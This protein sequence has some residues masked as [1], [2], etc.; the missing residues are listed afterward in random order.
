MQRSK[1]E[2]TVACSR[3][4]QGKRDGLERR[5]ESDAPVGGNSGKEQFE[6]GDNNF[7]QD[8]PSATCLR[9]RAEEGKEAK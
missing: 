5:L 3:F 7:G 4:K 2:M 1:L 6:A 9:S 8:T